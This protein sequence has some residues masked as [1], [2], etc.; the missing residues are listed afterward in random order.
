MA[1]KTRRG[2]AI[3]RSLRNSLQLSKR[4]RGGA[5]VVP[6]VPGIRRSMTPITAKS[7]YNPYTPQTATLLPN[8][9]LLSIEKANEP[10]MSTATVVSSRAPSRAGQANTSRPGSPPES[11]AAANEPPLFGEDP[12]PPSGLAAPVAQAAQAAPVAPVEAKAPYVFPRLPNEGP[13]INTYGPR[14]TMMR[15]LYLGKQPKGSGRPRR[16]TYKRKN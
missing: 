15:N 9:P 12:R 16:K 6:V 1:G 10:K 3:R 8:S 11:P 4:Q 2:R 13:R 5:K 7:E 14:K